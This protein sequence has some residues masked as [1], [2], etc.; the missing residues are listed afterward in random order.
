MTDCSCKDCVGAC[1]ANPG[2]PTPAEAARFIAEG[3]A[4]RLMCDWLEPSSLIDTDERIYLLA[5]AS[6]GHEGDFAPEMDFLDFAFKKGRCVF[7]D[8]KDRCEVHDR[9]PLQCRMTLACGS[10]PLNRL[11]NGYSNYDIAKLWNTDEGRALVADW[12]R[13]VGVEL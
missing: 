8:R 5:P 9:K 1:K 13:A 10:E 12:K 4:S 3:L 6:R 11:G 2:W 7:L